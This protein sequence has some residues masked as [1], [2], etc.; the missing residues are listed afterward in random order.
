MKAFRFLT[1]AF[2]LLVGS[3]GAVM[4]QNEGKH[5]GSTQDAM[6][7][8]MPLHTR[9]AEHVAQIPSPN[10]AGGKYEKSLYSRESG[11]YLD[12]GWQQGYAVLADHT[13]LD[14]LMLRYDI[15]NQQIQFISN[16]DTLAFSNPAELDYVQL[17]GRRF[18]Y[19]EYEHGG[20]LDRGY[21]EILKEGDC[22]LLLHRTVTHHIRKDNI[23]GFGED[24]F[25]RKVTYFIKK[26]DQV[27]RE[28]RASKKSV[29][30]AFEDE[31]DTIKHFIRT[32]NLKMKSCEDLI[33]VVAF[34]NSLH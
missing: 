28:V 6:R 14:H 15:Y 3:W 33:Q 1:V 30:C 7:Q 2:C 16:G 12:R 17:D 25:L 34:Y 9:S 18:I 27:A 11:M 23:A 26:E 4:A 5:L 10:E 19:E 31:K 21:F 8:G 32:N 20:V 24:E 29:Y 13:R 22:K